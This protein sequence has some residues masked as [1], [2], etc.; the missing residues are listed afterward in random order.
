MRCLGLLPTV[1]LVSVLTLIKA[2]DKQVSK[3][4]IFTTKESVLDMALTSYDD[5]YKGCSDVMEAEI[6]LLFQSEYSKNKE[7]AEAWDTATFRWEEKKK[8]AQVPQGF[9]DQYAIALLAYTI[10][11]PLFK[12]FNAAV[13]QAGQSRGYYLNNFNFKVLHYY[14]TKAL[15]EL[16][17]IEIP[18]CRK[19]FRGTQGIRFKP[20]SKKPMR[21]GQFTSSSTNDQNALQFGA[22][23]FF[24]IH[25]C[26]GV[27]I[28][29][30]SFF[31][32]EDEVL[33]PP[34][35]K[36]KVTNF[37]KDKDK[38]LIDLHSVEK[39]SV[40]NCEFVKEKRC[41]SKRCSFN[42]AT[43]TRMK[44]FSLE[45]ILLSVLVLLIH[46]LQTLFLTS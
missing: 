43:N 13:R 3:R 27:N 2:D 28:R 8:Y 26:Y 12:V 18:D 9:K 41:K 31:P 35:E 5:Q 16:D 29:N 42:S 30:F 32:G 23:T 36:F 17:A 10:N 45:F 25:T 33:I 19:V 44:M 6:P 39:S 7:F 11:G 40:Y 14:L 37:S 34:F 15:Q 24:N 21:F 20:E 1:T 46:P 4:D 38:Y 22:D